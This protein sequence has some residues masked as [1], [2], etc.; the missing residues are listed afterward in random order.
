MAK[1]AKKKLKKTPVT[2]KAITRKKQGSKP[3]RISP[4][5]TPA[6]HSPADRDYKAMFQRK[7]AENHLFYEVGRI[8]ASETEPY[9]LIKKIVAVINRE[10]PFLDASVYIA[11]RDMTGLEPFYHVGQLFENQTLSL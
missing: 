7:L 5:T 9:D 4:K 10:I 3:A 1:T 8:I 2:R 11:K 6:V